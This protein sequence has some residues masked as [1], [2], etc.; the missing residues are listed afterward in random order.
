MNIKKI[1]ATNRFFYW[2]IAFCTLAGVGVYLLTD[3]IFF[4]VAIFGLLQ[5]VLHHGE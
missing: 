1:V 4:G 5:I 3:V 2:W